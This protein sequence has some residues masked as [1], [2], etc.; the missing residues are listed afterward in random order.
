MG[1]FGGFDWR[2]PK[3]VAIQ[4]GSFMMGSPDDDPDAQ[5][6][7]NP[8][9]KVTIRKAFEIGK[10]PV[11][12]AEWDGVVKAGFVCPDTEF[13]VNHPHDGREG[14]KGWG[15]WQSPSHQCELG[16]RPGL[17]RLSQR[18]HGQGISSAIGGG[19]GICLSG[20]HDHA[21]FLWR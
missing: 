5:S 3:M 1:L 19:V 11:T 15:T 17:Y 14:K 6:D 4:A 10:Y 7:E 2:R 9:H 18:A 8:Q 12:F 20:G 13:A 16:R 21:I